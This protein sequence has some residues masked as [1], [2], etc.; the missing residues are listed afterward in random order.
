[1]SGTLFFIIIIISFLSVGLIAAHHY[2]TE[3]QRIDHVV[4]TKLIT[5]NI[6]HNRCCEY[7]ETTFMLYYKDGTH[8]AK[9]IDTNNRRLYDAYMSKIEM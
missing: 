8:E 6:R 7:I 3:Q 2:R 4:K 1:M 5:T 9:T